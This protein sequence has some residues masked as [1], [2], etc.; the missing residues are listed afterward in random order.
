MAKSSVARIYLIVLNIW[1]HA[2]GVLAGF[3]R[4]G[5]VLRISATA[6]IHFYTGSA[7]ADVDWSLVYPI[8]TRDGHFT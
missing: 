5:G 2:S 8:V 1:L 6:P 7:L 3:D 4:M